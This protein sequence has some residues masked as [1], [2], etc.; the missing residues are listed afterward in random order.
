D[1]V[2]VVEPAGRPGDVHLELQ[3][4]VTGKAL[5]SRDLAT[6]GRSQSA[7]DDEIADILTTVAP[8]SGIIYASL[9]QAGAQTTLI[10]CLG[11]N[12]TFYHDQ[13]PAAHREAYQCF[14]ALA[15]LE[16]KSALV[17]SEL[18]SLH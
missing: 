13:N 5:L 11:L 4:I 1:F 8:A 10:R 15:G 9:A 12:E 2:F 17:Y 16:P 6:A 18:S 7:I 14:E 3:N